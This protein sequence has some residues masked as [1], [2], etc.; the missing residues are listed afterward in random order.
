MKNTL[1]TIR[2]SWTYQH[3]TLILALALLTAHIYPLI[4]MPKAEAIQYQAEPVI[5]TSIE[6]KLQER[7]RE[8]YKEN[9]HMD[10]EKYRLEAIRELNTELL[11][12]IDESPFVDYEAMSETYGY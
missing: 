1:T 6:M 5:D 12:M 2:N 8:L 9:E 11:R 3:K 10:L 7:A 4:P